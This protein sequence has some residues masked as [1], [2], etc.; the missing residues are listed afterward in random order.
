MLLLIR[1]SPVV[2]QPITCAD[3]NRPEAADAI[4]KAVSKVLDD[5]IRT[6]MPNLLVGAVLCWCRTGAPGSCIA[7]SVSMLEPG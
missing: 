3:L 7:Y 6:G 5:K 2:A 1:T 4:E